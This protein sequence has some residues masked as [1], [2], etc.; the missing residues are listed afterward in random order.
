VSLIFFYKNL[1]QPNG[2]GCKI[3]SEDTTKIDIKIF[4]VTKIAEEYM[5]KSNQRK[6]DENIEIFCHFYYYVQK[7]L[8]YNFFE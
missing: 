2:I 1:A 8:T 5:Q 7:F 4:N 3:Y 6:W